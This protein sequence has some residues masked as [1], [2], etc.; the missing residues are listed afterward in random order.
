MS[1]YGLTAIGI[2]SRNA[3]L[4][5]RRQEFEDPRDAQDA[6]QGLQDVRLG[7]S[8]VRCEIA[9]NKGKNAAPVST[10]RGAGPPTGCAA[11]APLPPRDLSGSVRRAVLTHVLGL[12]SDVSPCC[13]TV[14][15]RAVLKNLPSTFSWKELKDEMRRI[16]DVIYA[17]VSDRGDGCARAATRGA[18]PCVPALSA[19]RCAAQ[20]R[21]VRLCRGP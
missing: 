17:D 4:S 8:R 11:A 1:D 14:K 7:N 10:G 15:H 16:G 13:R 2:T 21:R 9:K 12:W 19:P 5:V 3:S 6:V 18:Q 20:D